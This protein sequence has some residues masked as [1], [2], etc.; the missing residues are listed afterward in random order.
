[1][2]AATRDTFVVAYR[3][4]LAYVGDNH[5]IS[6]VG[7]ADDRNVQLDFD[8]LARCRFSLTASN[9]ITL[10]VDGKEM[11][12][13]LSTTFRDLADA[14]D[15][16]VMEFVAEAARRAFEEDQRSADG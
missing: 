2:S 7:P 6:L 4:E 10:H 11:S 15:V 1:M 3:G 5:E 9:A 14:I 8:E 13:A 16:A 12:H